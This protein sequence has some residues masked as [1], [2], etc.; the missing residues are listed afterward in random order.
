MTVRV[1]CNNTLSLSIRRGEY[2]SEPC[3]RIPHNTRF[4]ADRVKAKLGLA[5]ALYAKFEEEARELARA[6]ISDQEAVQ[7]LVRVLGDA[8][9]PAE[10]QAEAPT[11][12]SVFALWK[13]AGKGAFLSTARQSVWGLVNA[14]TQYIDHE[15]RSRTADNRLNAAWFGKGAETKHKA[16]AEAIQTVQ[17][18]IK[19]VK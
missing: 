16:W 2:D 19:V 15:R 10:E 13:G 6:S 3:I 11:I 14:V 1:V 9:K 17:G 7:W 8:N 4:D 12:K 18:R 5:P